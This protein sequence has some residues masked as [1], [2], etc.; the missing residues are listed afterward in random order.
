[1]LN[2]PWISL[3]KMINVAWVNSNNNF[4]FIVFIWTYNYSHHLLVIKN[5]LF[6]VSKLKFSIDIKINFNLIKVSLSISKL[7]EVVLEY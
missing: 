5:I 4:Q 3:I 6:G 7:N 2:F 1:M